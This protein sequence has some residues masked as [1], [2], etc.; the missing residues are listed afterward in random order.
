MKYWSWKIFNWN[1]EPVFYGSM[2]LIQ[3]NQYISILSYSHSH[4]YLV[5]WIK[6]FSIY[7]EYGFFYEFSKHNP[8][9]SKQLVSLQCKWKKLYK[10]IASKRLPEFNQMSNTCND[11]AL[12]LHL[13]CFI[14][15]ILLDSCH[16]WQL[17]LDYISRHCLRYP[18]I[19]A[20]TQSLAF[21]HMLAISSKRWI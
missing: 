15:L 14:F 6:G 5:R 10:C 9:F 2:S 13:N 12:F 20:I 4:C 18:A 17:I 3:S 1:F 16:W 7:F 19:I 8:E 11:L 21:L